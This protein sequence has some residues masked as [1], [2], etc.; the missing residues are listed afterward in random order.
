MGRGFFPLDQRLQLTGRS[1]TPATIV[2]ALRMSLEI[3]SY[4]RAAA[5]L[6]E[7]THVHLSKSSLQELVKE[8]GGQL[9]ARQ[10]EEAQATVA[11]PGKETEE[12]RR[13]I[14]E[15]PSAAMNISMDGAMVNI[16]GEG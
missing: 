12:V 5:Q 4:A 14:A 10:A 15:P 3:S 16:R 1:W 6:S 2:Q 8:Y 11:M 13:E 7:L 9:V